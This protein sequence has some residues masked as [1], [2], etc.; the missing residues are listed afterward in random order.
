MQVHPMMIVHMNLSF[1]IICKKNLYFQLK[2]HRFG[3][4]VRR[5]FTLVR[6]KWEEKEPET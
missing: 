5:M 4:K 6:V 1:E 2:I 3:E